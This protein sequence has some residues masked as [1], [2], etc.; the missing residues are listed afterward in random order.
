MR[1]DEDYYKT[2]AAIAHEV[3]H[4]W[5]HGN[6][7][8]DWIDEGRPAIELQIVAAYQEGQAIYPPITYCES[9]R[10]IDE[11][12]RGAPDRVSSANLPGSVATTASATESSGP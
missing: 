12:E 8:A 4:T 10:N 11:L 7:P 5:F 6:D 9:Y 1:V 2:F 3:A